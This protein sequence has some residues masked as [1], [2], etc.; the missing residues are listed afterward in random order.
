MG[1]LV[2]DEASVGLVGVHAEL[3]TSALELGKSLAR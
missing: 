3:G 1:M 2:D